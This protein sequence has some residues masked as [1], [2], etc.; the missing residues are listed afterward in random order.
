M[1]RVRN[2]VTAASDDTYGDVAMVTVDERKHEVG[3][4]L[5]ELTTKYRR[6]MEDMK[7]DVSNDEGEFIPSFLTFSG[8]ARAV[9]IF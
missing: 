6:E 7:T 5:R 1:L 4:F 3:A 2:E 9:A 8:L